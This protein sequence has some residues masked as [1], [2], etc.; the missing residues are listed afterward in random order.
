MNTNS[1]MIANEAR[2]LA[3]PAAWLLGFAQR[4]S[5]ISSEFVGEA[6]ARLLDFAEFSASQQARPAPLGRFQI[7]QGG[8]A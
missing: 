5:A 1:K 7:I 8:R 4:L 3:Q 2:E 6:P